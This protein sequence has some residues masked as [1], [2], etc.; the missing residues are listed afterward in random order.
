MQKSGLLAAILGVFFSPLALPAGLIIYGL[1]ETQEA[2]RFG[3][4]VVA[5]SLFVFAIS[6]CLVGLCST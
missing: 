2:R 6:L 1:A 3:E 5:W 4:T